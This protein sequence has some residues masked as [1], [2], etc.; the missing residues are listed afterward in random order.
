M[1][2]SPFPTWKS[3]NP[4]P[5]QEVVASLQSSSI[6]W[7]YRSLSYQ[8]PGWLCNVCEAVRCEND[9]CDGRL[10]SVPAPPPQCPPPTA[11]SHSHKKMEI[12]WWHPTCLGP[13]SA[14]GLPLFGSWSK[15]HCFLLQISYK[16]LIIALGI[17][18]DYEK[19]RL[20]DL[21]VPWPTS[22]KIKDTALSV[23]ISVWQ[24]KVLRNPLLVLF[25][26]LWF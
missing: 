11:P 25:L 2:F 18:L 3:V 17:Q 4:S 24:E 1:S 21:F 15:Q 8:K 16:Y 6:V 7:K 26:F 20:N 10:E 9:G 19:V 14:L 23:F 5:A 13:E 22:A 12:L